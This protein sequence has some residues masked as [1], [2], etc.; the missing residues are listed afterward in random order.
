VFDTSTDDERRRTL[1]AFLLNRRQRIDANAAR[2][3]TYMRR[4][5]R[6]GRPFTQEEIAEALDVSRQWYAALELSLPVRPS[7]ALLDR[8]ATLF[9]LHDDDRLTLFRL[10]IPEFGR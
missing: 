9:D 4:E 1:S 2:V 3:G 8:I 7:P 10:A 5:N 6:I